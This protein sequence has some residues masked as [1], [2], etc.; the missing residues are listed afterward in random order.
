MNQNELR[1]GNLVYHK[2]NPLPQKVDGLDLYKIQ[3]EYISEYAMPD[4]FSPIQLDEEWLLKFGFVKSEGLY[5]RSI[6]D[7]FYLSVDDKFIV[8]F[9]SSGEYVTDNEHG[10]VL[11]I[12]YVHQ[13][14]NLYFALTGKEL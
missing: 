11:S 7:H 12:Q 2:D 13:L 9:M 5:N 10:D 3:S 6:S 1:I 4:H 8:S 14:Q